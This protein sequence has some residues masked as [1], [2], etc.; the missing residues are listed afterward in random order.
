MEGLLASIRRA[1]Q[2]EDEAATAAP[3]TARSIPAGAVPDDIRAL[4]EKINSELS[5]PA[6]PVAPTAADT[7][8]AK[9]FSSLF[10]PPQPVE[11]SVPLRR[12]AVTEPAASA[13]PRAA[14]LPRL[15]P[16]V[17]EYEEYAPVASRPSAPTAVPRQ[18]EPARGLVSARVAEATSS[19][20]GRLAEALPPASAP[21]AGPGFE[22][23]TREMLQPMLQKWLD[24]NLPSIVERL[25]REEIE[26]VA[27]RGR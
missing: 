8:A 1:I 9:R 15:R 7:P 12:A 3:V 4:R 17:N 6:A 20:F 14:E 27:R 19:A 25:V 18:P 2:E 24:A 13:P 10:R 5:R 22:E 26:R 11:R 16:R 21:M 23:M